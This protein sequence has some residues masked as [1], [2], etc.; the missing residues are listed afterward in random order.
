MIQLVG[1]EA[2]PKSSREG[3]TLHQPVPEPSTVGPSHGE[4][5]GGLEHLGQGNPKVGPRSREREF[6]QDLRN[7]DPDLGD[8]VGI[9]AAILGKHHQKL[10]TPR[11]GAALEK[12]PEA[13]LVWEPV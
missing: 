8:L 1:L 13:K 2:I 6:G 4:L 12:P 9:G 7:I 5:G 3:K 11:V 10:R